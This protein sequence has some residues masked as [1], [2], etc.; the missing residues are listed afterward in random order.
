[1]ASLIKKLL[2][3]VNDVGTSGQITSPRINNYHA[4]ASRKTMK[5]SHTRIDPRV[6]LRWK[7]V[8]F[9]DALNCTAFIP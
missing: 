1:M 2:I 6:A 4:I 7:P 5:K 3:T 8:S 9:A